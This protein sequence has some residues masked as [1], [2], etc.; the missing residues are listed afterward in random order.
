MAMAGA[1]GVRLVV[2]KTGKIKHVL[3]DAGD[4]VPY[5]IVTEE[6]VP[7]SP[8]PGGAD[9]GDE[10]EDDECGDVDLRH[11]IHGVCLNTLQL[12]AFEKFAA[13]LPPR[14]FENAF[15][16]ASTAAVPNHMFPMGVAWALNGNDAPP[17][18]A[19]PLDFTCGTGI[20]LIE[21]ELPHKDYGLSRNWFSQDRVRK[22]LGTLQKKPMRQGVISDPACMEFVRRHTHPWSEETDPITFPYEDPEHSD[23]VPEINEKDFVGVFV[24][25]WGTVESRIMET[26]KHNESEPSHF[27][28]V[29]RGSLSDEIADQV[30]LSAMFRAQNGGTWLDVARSEEVRRAREMG[31]HKRRSVLDRVCEALDVV[32]KKHT[33]SSTDTNVFAVEND[34]VVYYAGCSTSQ[35]VGP[36]RAVFVNETGAPLAVWWL[37]GPYTSKIGGGQWS[38]HDACHAVPEAVTQTDGEDVLAALTSNGFDISGGFV[39]MSLVCTVHKGE[40]IPN[41]IQS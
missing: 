5:A 29:M 35:E 13:T 25:N 39:E 31:A 1:R 33:L 4:L 24:S 34:V 23:W 32:P 40:H 6:D 21:V 27:Y 16:T 36:G 19:F 11:K 20:T 38:A 9:S 41:I 18:D 3:D 2:D 26:E 15:C 37:H 10:D 30:R 28:V 22:A 12:R 7:G 17:Q 14:V 8:R